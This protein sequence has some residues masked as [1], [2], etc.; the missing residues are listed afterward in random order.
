MK[1]FQT[2]EFQQEKRDKN[3]L[4]TAEKRSM[5]EAKAYEYRNSLD[6]GGQFHDYTTPEERDRING[7]IQKNI[8]DWLYQDEVQ[9][10]S[11]DQL[12]IQENTLTLIMQKVN[13]RTKFH[14][15]IEKLSEDY[16][17]KANEV[18]E[19][20]GYIGKGYVKKQYTKQ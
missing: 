12:M 18:F 4:L 5:L 1:E 17:K 6:Q 8:I 2:L 19:F 11:I 9:N 10:A 16:I 14:A 20:Y 7:E 3:I 15:G 13:D